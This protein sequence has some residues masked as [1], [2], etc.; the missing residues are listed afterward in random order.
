[1]R[2]MTA[3]VQ[4]MHCKLTLVLQ[5]YIIVW[6]LVLK[7]KFLNLKLL[8]KESS[9]ILFLLGNTRNMTS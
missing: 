1:M 9:D 2:V 8:Q 6:L 5:H 4:N 7:K 3:V